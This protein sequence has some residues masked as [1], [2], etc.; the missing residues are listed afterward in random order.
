MERRKDSRDGVK[1]KRRDSDKGRNAELKIGKVDRDEQ[2]LGM[3]HTDKRR[4]SSFIRKGKGT[5]QL[6]DTCK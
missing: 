3:G 2:D 4:W 6:G 1:G 5:D